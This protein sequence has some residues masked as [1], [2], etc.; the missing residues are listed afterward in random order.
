MDAIDSDLESAVRSGAD[1]RIS[2]LSAGIKRSGIYLPVSGE[3]RVAV[4]G[5]DSSLNAR[6]LACLTREAAS[7]RFDTSA[8]ADMLRRMASAVA[9]TNRRQPG[10]S[11]TDAEVVRRI[12]QLHR[13]DPGMSRTTALR[14]LRRRGEACEQKRFAYLWSEVA[15]S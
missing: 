5:T 8:M 6:L 14:E 7:H 3:L 13:I 10:M 1:D 11:L 2:V 4:S 15:A 12:H 9:D